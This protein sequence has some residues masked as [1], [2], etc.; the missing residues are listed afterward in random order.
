MIKLVCPPSSR[1]ADLVSDGTDLLR[2]GIRALPA[3][4]EHKGEV[5]DKDHHLVSRLEL[6][7]LGGSVVMSLLPLLSLGE[8]FPN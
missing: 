5:G 1:L 3:G 6:S 8:V 7:R 2:D 4:Q